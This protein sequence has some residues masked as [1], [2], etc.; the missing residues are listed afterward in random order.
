MFLIYFVLGMTGGVYAPNFFAILGDFSPEEH[1]GK[2][3]S[4]QSINDNI[5][6][7]IAPLVGGFLWDT[8]SPISAWYLD[9]ASTI[10]AGLIFLGLL[11]SV[12]KMR[13]IP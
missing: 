2:I 12:R 13:E 11:L 9:L 4:I 6:L 7:I 5:F 8:I 3:Y 10:I 1:R